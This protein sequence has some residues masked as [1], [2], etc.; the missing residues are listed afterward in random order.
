MLA[1]K[2]V[3]FNTSPPKKITTSYDFPLTMTLGPGYG[4]TYYF[5]LSRN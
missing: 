3:T 1:Y 5:M 2:D 4:G